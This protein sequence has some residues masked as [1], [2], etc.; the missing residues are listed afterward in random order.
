MRDD[1]VLLYMLGVRVRRFSARMG[2]TASSRA[3]GRSK[4]RT[5]SGHPGR[6]TREPRAD[7]LAVPSSRWPMN[8][9]NAYILGFVIAPVAAF[10]CGLAAY[11]P[12]ATTVFDFAFFEQSSVSQIVG[13]RFEQMRFVSALVYGLFTEISFYCVAKSIPHRPV[14]HAPLAMLCGAA[15][16]VIL[17]SVTAFL[18]MA[19]SLIAL[20]YALFFNRGDA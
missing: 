6:V 4:G 12:L 8:K 7:V 1:P 15:A 16:I 14:W 10:L 17:I 5:P 11:G 18:V 20:F 13:D 9:S 2:P 3:F 19:L